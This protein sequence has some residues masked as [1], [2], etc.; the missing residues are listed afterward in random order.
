MYTQLIF[1][2]V[3]YFPMYNYLHVALAVYTRSPAAYEAVRNFRLI[4]LPSVR[5]LKQ[6]IDANL[7]DVG[8]SRARLVQSRKNY[9]VMVEEKTK[10]VEKK[11]EEQGKLCK[12]V[13]VCVCACVCVRERE[14]ER[15]RVCVHLCIQH[16]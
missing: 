6:F 8:D 16:V 15:E 10:E 13:C 14:G 7:E 5:F 3:L 4:Q 1:N 9:L 12:C 11:I 2:I